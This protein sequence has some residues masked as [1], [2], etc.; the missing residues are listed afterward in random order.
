MLQRFKHFLEPKQVVISGTFELKEENGDNIV[1]TCNY[2]TITPNVDKVEFY[3]DNVKVENSEV[4]I[5][6]ICYFNLW[7]SLSFLIFKSFLYLT[8]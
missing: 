4:S 7:F 3:I 2:A 8:Y 6:L 5:C 1:F